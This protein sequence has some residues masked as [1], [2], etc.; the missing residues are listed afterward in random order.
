MILLTEKALRFDFG[1]VAGRLASIIDR[2]PA[3]TSF[4]SI[5]FVCGQNKFLLIAQGG[6]VPAS[7][8]CQ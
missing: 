5:L 8:A 2:T 7:G 1:D 4:S 3:F 6:E